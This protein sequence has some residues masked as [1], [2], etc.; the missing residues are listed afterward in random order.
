MPA[1]NSRDLRILVAEDDPLFAATVEDFLTQE[2]YT[3]SISVDGQDALETASSMHIAAL[4]TD[5]RMPRLDGIA[6]VRKLREARPDLPVVVMTG[7]APDNWNS[8]LQ[9]ESEAPLILL[10]KPVRLSNLVRALE[11]V[12][13]SGA[14]S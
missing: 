7:Y 11:Q 3:V 12:L 4:V 13:H 14:G 9:R 1:E 8:F 2:G 10:E 6:L 5:L